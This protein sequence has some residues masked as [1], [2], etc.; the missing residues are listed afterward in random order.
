MNDWL[1]YQGSGSS[2]AYANNTLSHA[3][4]VPTGSKQYD[5]DERLINAYAEKMKKNIYI[6]TNDQNGIHG[7]N[8]PSPTHQ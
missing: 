1:D 5:A 3:S 8:M 6:I 2:R 7:Q 4:L